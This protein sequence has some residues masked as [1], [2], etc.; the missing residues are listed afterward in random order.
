MKIVCVE[1]VSRDF[2]RF[3][4]FDYIVLVVIYII[5]KFIEV[6]FTLFVEGNDFFFFFLSTKT[7]E[8][9]KEKKKR[10]EN[11]ARICVRE[12]SILKETYRFVVEKYL[13]FS[14]VVAYE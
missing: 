13:S 3:P 11:R 8:K 1:S 9:K 14:L 10:P 7:K 5:S 12:N 4:K 6:L 2:I